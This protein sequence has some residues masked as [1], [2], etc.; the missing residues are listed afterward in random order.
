VSIPGLKLCA[1][2]S[3]MPRSIALAENAI[4]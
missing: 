3:D 2:L 4:S 1:A